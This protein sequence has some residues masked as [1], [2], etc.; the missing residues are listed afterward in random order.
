MT[1][2]KRRFRR[3]AERGT[4]VLVVVMITT[5]ITAIGVFAVRNI[6]QIDQAVGYSRQSAQTTALAEL[7]A[8]AALSQIGVNGSDYAKRMDGGQWCLAN[9][10]Y[11]KTPGYA[12]M[13]LRQSDMETTTTGANAE[14]LLE[15][16]V[17]NSE[18]GSFG[19]VA[20]TTG[21]VFAELTDKYQT[22]TPRAGVVQGG[23]N[24]F[25]VTVTTMANVRPITTSTD[26]CGD[27]VAATTVKKM[28]RVHTI[29][30]GP[31]TTSPG[32]T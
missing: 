3:K 14:T 9:D 20:N 25:D 4:T 7:G 32:G 15:P 11:A 18:S 17:T 1:A 6:S 21:F 8:T 13:V 28:M 29:M 16:A 19:P 2:G 23:T 26:P 31:P 22:N 27:N 12:C 24:F 5:L 30:P 10:R